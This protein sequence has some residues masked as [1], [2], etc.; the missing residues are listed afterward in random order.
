MRCLSDWLPCGIRTVDAFQSTE[1]SLVIFNDKTH[2]KKTSKSSPS[3]FDPAAPPLRPPG[4][5]SSGSPQA[6][7]SDAAP[8]LCPGIG[9]I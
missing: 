6:V 1:P 8:G 3:G 2:R 5:I 7:R 4:I 9:G